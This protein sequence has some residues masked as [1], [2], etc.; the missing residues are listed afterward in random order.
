MGAVNNGAD[1]W[2][3]PTGWDDLKDRSNRM[4]MNFNSDMM[5]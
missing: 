5:N 1:E 3:G 2:V 4:S